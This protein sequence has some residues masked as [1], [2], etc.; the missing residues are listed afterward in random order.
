[1]ML[2]ILVVPRKREKKM[3]TVQ[4]LQQTCLTAVSHECRFL[5]RGAFVYIAWT[6]IPLVRP[7]LRKD[8]AA[9]CLII[10]ANTNPFYT[11][12]ITL[13]KKTWR[14]L[15]LCISLSIVYMKH[16]EV[17]ISRRVTNMSTELLD[18]WKNTE[19][20]I[21][22]FQTFPIGILACFLQPDPCPP[23]SQ[24]SQACGYLSNLNFSQTS[25]KLGKDLK[26]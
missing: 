6:V 3:S 11:T 4:T 12:R 25:E 23:C 13:E 9:L 1:M 5:I 21:V 8:L 16:L 10:S 22:N 2:Q 17:H 20:V 24:Q 26:S 19:P 14:T 7:T 15:L 18:K